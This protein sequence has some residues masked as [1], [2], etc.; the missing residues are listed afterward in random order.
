VSLSFE[1]IKKEDVRCHKGI[2]VSHS[3]FSSFWVQSVRLC[4][5]VT[6]VLSH[7]CFIMSHS[8]FLGFKCEIVSQCDTYVLSVTLVM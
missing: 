7:K 5:S 3:E 6:H 1:G 4:H 2:I 8:T